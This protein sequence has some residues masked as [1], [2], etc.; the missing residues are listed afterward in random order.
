MSRPW[1]SDPNSLCTEIPSSRV[2]RLSGSSGTF[3][4]ASM[5]KPSV[6]RM[7]TLTLSCRSQISTLGAAGVGVGAGS[8]GA[9]CLVGAGS[10]VAA[11]GCVGAG[12]SVGAAGSAGSRDPLTRVGSGT[13]VGMLARLVPE[14]GVLSRSRRVL[15][16]AGGSVGTVVEVSVGMM[17]G[18]ASRAATRVL[19]VSPV[20]PG[21]GSWLSPPQATRR[22]A[23]AGTLPA[24]PWPSRTTTGSVLLRIRGSAI[25][26][27]GHPDGRTVF[28]SGTE[29]LVDRDL[30]LVSQ[31]G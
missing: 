12:G 9:A 10:S 3:S 15:P 21:S 5:S 1:N 8:V 28:P 31:A 30:L 29:S 27:G 16:P 24:W 14:T 25:P 11:G 18:A 26:W 17:V 2:I 23:T 6:P 20:S 13:L 22:A 7:A 4:H 19:P